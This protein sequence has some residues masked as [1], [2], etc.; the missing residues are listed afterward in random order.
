MKDKKVIIIGS[1]I[2]GLAAAM[3]LATCGINVQIFEKQAYSGGKIRTSNSPAGLIDC[4]PTV[5][6]MYEV[7]EEQRLSHS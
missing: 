4:G 6:T 1:G 5:L 7:F 3:R 2:G